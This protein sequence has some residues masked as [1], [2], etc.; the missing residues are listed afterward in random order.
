MKTTYL[1]LLGIF[2]SLNIFAQ[3]VQK[4]TEPASTYTIKGSVV[5]S[6]SNQSVQYAT[7]SI[8]SSRMP[9]NP[10]KVV[11]S[12]NNGNFAATFNAPPGN[13]VINIQF[14]GMRPTTKRFTINSSQKIVS[15]GKIYMTETSAQLQ[16][17]VVVAQK[18]LVKVEIDKLTYSIDNDPDAK[19]SNTLDMLKKVP[20]IT[21]DNDDNIQLKGSSD[22]KIYLNGKPS[23]IL[24]NNPGDV[25][26]GMP[27]NSIKNV[28]V[29]TDP[30]AK[31][32]AEGVGGIINIITAKSGI[33]GYSA[34]VRSGVSTLGRWGGG[35]YL[36]L[37][38]GKFGIT[39]NYNYNKMN[40]PYN[41]SYMERIN[42][43]STNE[44]YMTQSGRAKN[45]GP[46][47]FGTLEGSYEIDSLNLISLSVQRF[48]GDITN[49]SD[50]LVD[51]KD[52][53]HSPYYS[54]NRNSQSTRT[55]GSTDFDFDYQRSTHL[56]DELFTLSYKFENNPNNSESYTLLENLTGAVPSI[57]SRVQRNTNTASTKEH[58]AQ[59]DYTRPLKKGQKLDVGVKY[60]RRNSNSETE[61]WT[62]D[63]IVNNPAND[64]KH[65]Q[66]IYSAY[67][68]YD[69]KVKNVGLKAGVREE[70]TKQTVKYQLAPEMNFDTH[71]SN[72]VPSASA[73]YSIS[74]TEQVRFGYTMRIRRPSIRNL[75][76]YVNNTD[77]QN[78]SYGNPNLNPEKSNNLSLNYSKFAQKLNINLGLSYNFVNNGIESYTFIDPAKPNVSQTTYDNIG[79][80][81]RTSFSI[82]GNWNATKKINVI[83]NGGVFYV[84]MKSDATQSTE[85]LSNSG[86]FYNGFTTIQYTLPKDFRLTLNGG[87]FAP[88]V[89]LQGKSSAFY[90]TSIALNKDFLNKK[91]SVSISCSDPFWKNKEYTS[92]TTSQTF[93][94]KSINYVNTR[95]VR[96]NISYRF[97][98]LNKTAT[99]KTKQGIS[100]DDVKTEENQEENINTNSR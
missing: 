54:Y 72:L 56:K 76:P 91:L 22:F 40:S 80:S 49:L 65:T 51:M 29:I 13:Y 15:L 95:E 25:L 30:G 94:M 6:I 16:E 75:N 35:A 55:F 14:V 27:A 85:Q 3:N 78:I 69:M 63:T 62:N 66:N 46:F 67:I 31:Y 87:Y 7:L 81:Q 23:N 61:Q 96:I 64:F 12:D 17:V 34:T 43:V 99:K 82:Y 18:P 88:R 21:V 83:L 2:F 92:R 44:K 57:L 41:D 19:T 38:S 60:I 26:K 93:S 11:V 97:G 36:S 50:Y 37:K 59:A 100:N 5:D 68:S 74:A 53:N 28:E 4:R 70:A 24:T 71:Y 39:G 9:Q 58:T 86:F 42:N 20:M 84:N 77:P 89:N 10:L 90:N 79:H 33:E 32:D 73:S 47:Q 48:N 98:N 45:K 1:L 52:A 8:A